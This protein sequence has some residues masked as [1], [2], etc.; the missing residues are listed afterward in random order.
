MR[1]RERKKGRGG[2]RKKGG[3][4]AKEGGGS[5]LFLSRDTSLSSPFLFFPAFF[6]MYAGIPSRDYRKKLYLVIKG[7]FIEM[8]CFCQGRKNQNSCSLSYDRQI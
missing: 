8:N 3:K 7:R 4:G 1:E 5:D 2:K 6:L